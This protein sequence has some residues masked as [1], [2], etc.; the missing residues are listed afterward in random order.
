MSK[1]A[2]STCLNEE[3][4]R[5]CLLAC[6]IVLTGKVPI[7]SAYTEQTPHGVAVIPTNKCY[8]CGICVSKCDGVK[9]YDF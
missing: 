1:K 2:I 7:N 3:C 9:L 8:G 5:K 4:K 6:P